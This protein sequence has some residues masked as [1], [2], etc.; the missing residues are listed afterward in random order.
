MRNYFYQ[1]ILITSTIM[2]LAA[3]QVKAQEIEVTQVRL[4]NT[5]SGIELFLQSPKPELL[6]ITSK[7]ESNTYIADIPNA[8]LHLSSG[9]S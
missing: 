1:P 7:T 5:A 8:E 2:L 6:Q 9:T 4:Q 3:Q